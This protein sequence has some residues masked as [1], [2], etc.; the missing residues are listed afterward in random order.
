M[1]CLADIM[2]IMAPVNVRLSQVS[3][4][5]VGIDV[6]L[7][8]YLGLL[9]RTDYPAISH[10]SR[11]GIQKNKISP[12]PMPHNL[13]RPKARSLL[14]HI[15]IVAFHDFHQFPRFGS[16]HPRD[17]PHTDRIT[18]IKNSTVIVRCSG[19]AS[20]LPFLQ[21]VQLSSLQNL[22]NN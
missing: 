16:V 13:Q 3:D 8:Y 4:A 20:L 7:W 9:G 12:P 18:S 11:Q 22:I 10:I 1:P 19:T 5:F 15:R 2:I 17:R 14:T 6:R 21:Q